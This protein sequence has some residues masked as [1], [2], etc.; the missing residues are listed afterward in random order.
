MHTLLLLPL[1]LI[2]AGCSAADYRRSVE[3]RERPTVVSIGLDAAQASQ[4]EWRR[5]LLGEGS[6]PVIGR[7]AVA[8]L[9]RRSVPNKPDTPTLSATATRERDQAYQRP[10]TERV[11]FT[12]IMTIGLRVRLERRERYVRRSGTRT[13]HF[14]VGKLPAGELDSWARTQ[15]RE[16]TRYLVTS[17]IRDLHPVQRSVKLAFLS[18]GSA[19]VSRGIELAAQGDLNGS[20]TSFQ[21]ASRNA[22]QFKDVPLY[23]LGLLREATGQRPQAQALFEQA[24]LL[25]EDPRYLEAM[26]RIRRTQRRKDG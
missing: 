10:A 26:G 8:R 20:A 6:D 9:D 1:L 17:L 18:D 5:V 15:R 4:P 3:V 12:L 13:E 24:W 22:I 25:T 19:P 21:L 2:C 23:N 11:Q 14:D 16:L 7:L